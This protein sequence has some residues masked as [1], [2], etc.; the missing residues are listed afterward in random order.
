MQIPGEITLKVLAE[1]C[2]NTCLVMQSLP[3]LLRR[4]KTQRLCENSYHRPKCNNKT[5][6]YIILMYTFPS[7]LLIVYVISLARSQRGR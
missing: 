1:R 3:P 5:T 6:I 2:T 7:F 4:Q